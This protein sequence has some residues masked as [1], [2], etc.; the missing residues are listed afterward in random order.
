MV[1]NQL[2]R[3]VGFVAHT[4]FRLKLAVVPALVVVAAIILGMGGNSQAPPNVTIVQGD[5]NED[6]Y[7]DLVDLRIVVANFGPLPFNQPRA[8]INDSLAV[9]VLDLALVARN[10]GRLAPQPLRAMETERSFPNLTFARLTNL[11][12][13]GDGRNLIFVT[14]QQ[15]TIRVF[16]N[17]QG[18]TQAGVFLD[19]SVR[20]NEGAN[21]EGLL[22]LAFHPDYKLN[23][24][25]Y[26][27]YSAANPRR[28]VVSRFSVSQNNPDVADPQSAFVIL[29]VIQPFGNHNGGEITFGPD[30]YL[31]IGLGDGGSGGD[32]FLNG[33]NPGTLLGSL[34]RIDVG[35]VS[36]GKNYQV[37]S[38]NPFVGNPD[39]RDEVWA[40]GMRNPWRFS[41]DDHTGALWV[42]EVGQ[43]TWE[44]ID[45]VEKGLNYGW[46]TMEGFHC[47][48]SS[49]NCNQTGL[50]LPVWEY[51]LTGGNCS[52][53]GGYVYRGRGM[54]S[55]LGA[56][57]YADYCSGRVWGLRYDGGAVTEQMLLV[58]SSLFITAFGQD[59]DRNIYL[60]S[61]DDGIYRLVPIK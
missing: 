35:A 61:R 48:P 43:D 54:P 53:I 3:S 57:V 7:I 60:L 44:E 34:L 19:I 12:Q 30:G 4:T 16:P 13:P 27:Y 50:E 2:A 24:F 45:V 59:V 47:F 8:D 17:D 39:A 5:V 10:L 56:Y 51:S 20:V 36:E 9:D 11:V 46:N 23:G 31:Y 38:D 55:L 28:S 29:E 40:Y 52:V 58:D 14:E 41:I 42:G 18:A 15:G 37:P 21:E 25:F 33:Q 1:I 6:G 22:G 49:V 26:V 32:P